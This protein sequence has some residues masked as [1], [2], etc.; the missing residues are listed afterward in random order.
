LPLLKSQ[1]E[2]RESF[3]MFDTDKSG[4]IS[5]TEL[6]LTMK[7]FRPD[8]SK[9]EIKKLFHQIDVNKDNRISFEGML[10]V[11]LTIKIYYFEFLI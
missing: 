2:L 10:S 11:L 9:D 6:F 5:Q 3:A 7:K 8:V 4:S 1:K